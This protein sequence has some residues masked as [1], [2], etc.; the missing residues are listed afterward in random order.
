MI[1]LNINEFTYISWLTIRIYLVRIIYVC[2]IWKISLAS[3]RGPCRKDS[4]NKNAS[5]DKVAVDW[6]LYHKFVITV[7]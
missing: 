6:T 7:G 5:V 2:K 4:T 1:K 3:I